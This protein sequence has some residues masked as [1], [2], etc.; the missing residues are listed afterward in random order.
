MTN[1]QKD[2]DAGPDD[3]EKMMSLL[4][5]YSVK[6]RTMC[7]GYN[8]NLIRKSEISALSLIATI[9]SVTIA[10]TVTAIG[11]NVDLI[12]EFDFNEKIAVY[13]FVGIGIVVSLSAFAGTISNTRYRAQYDMHQVAVTLEKIVRMSS[14][15]GEHAIR[16]IGDRFEF[17][18]RLA[19]AEASLRVYEQVF[20]RGERDSVPYLVRRFL[21]WL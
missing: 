16:K 17:E 2:Y 21:P 20:R 14:Q 18:I 1:Q 10:V 7:D 15:Y 3:I 19:E 5:E 9:M 4:A 12:K 8:K 6:L 13:V 11:P